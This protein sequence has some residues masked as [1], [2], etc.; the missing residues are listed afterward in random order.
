MN[1]DFNYLITL[2]VKVQRLLDSNEDMRS[3][4]TR[5]STAVSKLL[6]ENDS[7]KVGIDLSGNK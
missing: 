3:E 4:I 6:N 2:F 5:L 1:Y 7:L